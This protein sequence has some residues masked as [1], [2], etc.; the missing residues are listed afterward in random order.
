MFG[1]RRVSLALKLPL[2]IV[3]MAVA[4]AL[5]VV[6]KASNDARTTLS[7]SATV[8]G[9]LIAQGRINELHQWFN[10]L[11]ATV[12]TVAQN[13]DTV[14]ALQEYQ[15]AFAELSATPL[16]TVQQLYIDKN[17]NKLGEKDK[18]NDAGD[19]SVYS[20]VHARRHPAFHAMQQR[21]GLYD[22]FLI[23]P[24]GDVVYSVFKERD[25]GSNLNTGVAAN[26]GLAKVFKTIVSATQPDKVALADFE[27]YAPSND[28]P[29]SFMA[30]G[31][32]GADGQLVGVLAIQ[33]PI[34]RLSAVFNNDL[35][36]GKTGQI[37]LVGADGLMRS[38]GR[39][40]K[41]NTVLSVKVALPEVA[42]AIEGKSGAAV[43]TGVDGAE[44]LVSY[45]PATIPG[46]RWALVVEQPTDELFAS[47][48]AGQR[49]TL[50]IL[51]F[52][53]IVI[54][55]IGLWLGR[56]IARPL[57][58]AT[59]A[60]QKLAGHDLTITPPV[61][62]SNDEVSDIS[63]AI[64]ILRDQLIEADRLAAEQ[65]E[66]RQRAAEAQARNAEM[67]HQ[68][69]MERVAEQQRAT[70]EQSRAVVTAL[71]SM[72]E[73]IEQELN[74]C[75]QQITHEAEEM[76]SASKQLSDSSTFVVNESSEA[77]SDTQSALQAAQAVASASEEM[78]AT[79]G[80]IARQVQ[81]SAD[82]SRQAV[83]AADKTRDIVTGLV[84]AA[85]EIETVVS[86][87]SAIAEQTNLLALNATIE[88]ARAGD[89][90]RGF[91]VVASEVKSLAGQTGK[92]T[93]TIRAQVA[94]IQAVVDEAV[95]AID[96]INTQIANVD[97][98]SSMIA[99]SIEE[100]SVATQ[101]ISNSVQRAAESVGMV[102]SR[103]EKVRSSALG[104]AENAQTV[105]SNAD[106]LT[107][108][109]RRLREQLVRMVRSVVP[110][111]DRRA[112]PRVKMQIRGQLLNNGTTVP[113]VIETVD[114]SP[115]G[116]RI[117][118]QPPL[119]YL[120]ETVELRF[121]GLSE[122]IRARV[123]EHSEAIV[124]LCFDATEQQRVQLQ[125]MVE[126][127]SSRISQAA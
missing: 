123:I 69:E 119:P 118:L 18:M 5:F 104:S 108:T 124:R 117:E 80:E 75:I 62:R 77:D 63:A 110:E 4:S 114:I 6:V 24:Q 100:Q 76:R 47:F 61:V 90:G 42:Q 88:S 14:A 13:P 32:F 36:L 58:G 72:A 70:E 106:H 2:I 55:F 74:S 103:V 89:A 37:R 111:V 121:D 116:A 38:Q 16:E 50:L 43:S 45:T 93:E 40:A 44:A 41:D 23:S 9:E 64:G 46:V 122:T 84:T 56:G 59:D 29:A 34:D 12:L 92:L 83:H 27:K 94:S 39:F 113:V 102:A 97:E 28:A 52:G 81:R 10:G 17:P 105:Y 91:A 112:A 101:E 20:Q 126:K 87:I 54:A 73:A 1:T 99:A 78:S 71:Q 11:E 96:N 82:V 7:S 68:A 26:S 60:L 53:L 107:E 25:F 22:V 98:G 115:L 35:G 86:A 85:D 31:L 19:G 79:I 66:L 15:Q 30:T 8:E 120:P 125:S 33:L 49:Q 51:G 109:T 65:E 67:Q 3:G 95:G 48:R 21:S 57:V 127:A